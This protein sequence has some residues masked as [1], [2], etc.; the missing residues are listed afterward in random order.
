MATRAVRAFVDGLVSVVLPAYLVVLGLDA[1]EVGAIV[2]GT[3][4]GSAA[5]TLAVGLRGHRL[6]RLR[7]LQA[8]AAAMVATGV[9]F[10][11]AA[12]FWALLVIAVLGT[13]N[14]SA[15]DVSVFLPTEQALLPATV[16][17][18]QRTALFAR[19]SLVGFV[20][21]AVG[22]LAAGLP[23]WLADRSSLSEEAA[24]RGVFF[25]Y[26]LAGV[27]VWLAYRRLSPSVEP[28]GDAPH[29]ALGPSRSIVYRLAAVFSLDSLG[30][31]FVVQSLLVLWLSRRHDL[32]VALTGAVFFWTGLLAGASALL[33][34]RIAARI[35]LIRT[36]VFT[37]LPANVLLVATPFMPNGGLAV[38]CLLLRA[39]LSQM[40][41][42]TRTSYVMAVVTPP[43]RPAA[44]SVTSVP[45][46]LASAAA[47][48]A[49]GWLLERSTFGW[50]LVVGG[51]L[52]IA[53]DLVLLAM[54]RNV[55]PPEELT[56]AR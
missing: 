54:F 39:T 51:C 25:A 46:S 20:V 42:P 16:A 6:S 37:H 45:R 49:A 30:G 14:P 35:G 9:A 1:L 43:E 21:A 5:L 4:V 28:A 15:G 40:D 50:P 32:S 13:L 8:V 52:K 18:H 41:V 56:P 29:R 47:P 31:G 44:A 36:M 7:L 23:G 53:Y 19:Y 48:L 10:G 3:L 12:S 24:L 2:T 11:A 26:A 22:S 55:R 33:A 17:D 27:V 34:V 38:A